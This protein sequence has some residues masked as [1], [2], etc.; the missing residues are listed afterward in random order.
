MIIFPSK[1]DIM[2]LDLVR[3]G[4]TTKSIR[5]RRRIYKAKR[6]DYCTS[7]KK[8]TWYYET[9]CIKRYGDTIGNNANQF[10]AGG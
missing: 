3:T 7:I 5:V 10:V 8:Y 4:Y 6:L 9:E 1:I 2:A